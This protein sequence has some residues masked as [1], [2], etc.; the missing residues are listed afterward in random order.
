MCEYCKIKDIGIGKVWECA[1]ATCAIRWDRMLV[2]AM[3]GHHAEFEVDY[4]PHCGDELKEISNE[5]QS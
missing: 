5:T 3:S 4:C 2:V 1:D